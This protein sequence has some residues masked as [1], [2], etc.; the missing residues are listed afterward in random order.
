MYFYDNAVF[1]NVHKAYTS[2]FLKGQNSAFTSFPRTPVCETHRCQFEMVAGSM[3]L[4]P[5]VDYLVFIL[6]FFLFPSGAR[7]GAVVSVPHPG[8]RPSA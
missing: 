3:Q 4:L 1:F 6:L 8:C 7:H 2:V 5:L